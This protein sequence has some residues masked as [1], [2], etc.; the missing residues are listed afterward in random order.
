MTDSA[1]DAIIAMA[2][3]TPLGLGL[4]VYG[5]WRAGDLR[6]WREI[7]V[8]VGTIGA[9]LILAA[10]FA[11]PPPVTW[12]VPPLALLVGGIGWW[13]SRPQDRSFPFGPVL[14]IGLGSLGLIS[15]ALR[16][17]LG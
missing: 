9:V 12:L 14:F 3:V 8:I 13:M 7:L 11:G 1:R 16:L 17:V 6:L 2:V 15:G 5:R 4:W 10:A